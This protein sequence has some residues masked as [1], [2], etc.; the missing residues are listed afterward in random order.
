MLFAVDHRPYNMILFMELNKD[1]EGFAVGPRTLLL[2][3]TFISS[4]LRTLY[5]ECV[6]LLYII[7]YSC[8]LYT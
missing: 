2:F 4:F 7:H 1:E 5:C 3:A 8:P 6:V